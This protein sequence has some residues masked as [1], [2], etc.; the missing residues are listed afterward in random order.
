MFPCADLVLTRGRQHRLHADLMKLQAQFA[1]ASPEERQQAMQIW[2]IQNADRLRAMRPLTFTPPTTP[3]IS[4]LA[5]LNSPLLN[6]T[7]K[8]TNPLTP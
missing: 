4:S 2:H 3:A 8:I 7:F 6:L 5:H 1:K